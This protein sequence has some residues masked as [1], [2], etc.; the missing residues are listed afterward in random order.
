MFYQIILLHIYCFAIEVVS[1]VSM[2]TKSAFGKTIQ[3]NA[4]ATG[5]K[6]VRSTS[7]A[8]SLIVCN[9]RCL[10]DN[11]CEATNYL[12]SSSSSYSVGGVC[13]LLGYESEN[14]VTFEYEKH[15]IYTKLIKV[16]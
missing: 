11:G 7:N 15:A 8:T 6:L 12:T 1:P 13:Q 9:L 2:Q 5:A 10:N 16:N 14:G 3:E 4:K